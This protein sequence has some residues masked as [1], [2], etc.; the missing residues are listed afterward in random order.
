MRRET[1]EQDAGALRRRVSLRPAPEL[2][3]TLL[4]V[5]GG[6]LFMM[7]WIILGIAA[8]FV[9]LFFVSCA[10][11][12]HFLDRDDDDQWGGWY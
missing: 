8:F 3:R 7:G 2:A 9:V 6:V 4:G 12:S 1:H 5:G 10:I 11:L